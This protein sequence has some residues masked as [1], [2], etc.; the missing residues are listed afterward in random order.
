MPGRAIV[1][2]CMTVLYFI[3]LTDRETVPFVQDESGIH[4]IRQEADLHSG[5]NELHWAVI[6]DPVDGNGGVLANLTCD[7]VKEA[8][9][10]PMPGF[11]DTQMVLRFLITFQ[12]R[13]ADTGMLVLCG[14]RKSER[15]QK[16]A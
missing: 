7:A 5:R 10:K 2:L 3:G 12:R 1:P 4:V 13:T 16:T 6:A 11:G 14:K 8:V 15:T 9:V